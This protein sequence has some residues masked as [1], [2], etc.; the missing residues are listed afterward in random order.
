MSILSGTTAISGAYLG[1]DEVSAIFLGG[2]LVWSPFF[3]SLPGTLHFA[4]SGDDDTGDGSAGNPFRSL[5]MAN[6][7]ATPGRTIRLRGGDTFEGT[8][9]ATPGCTY[10]SY[11]TGQATVLSG[12]AVGCLMLNPDNT[13]V[14]DLIFEGAGTEVNATAGILA[15]NIHSGPTQVVGTIIR[16]CHVSEYGSNGIYAEV[17]NYPSGFTNL[18]IEDCVV[19]DCTGNDR[20]GHTAGIVVGAEN[21]WGLA[22]FPTSHI[23]PIVRGCEVYRCRGT[24]DASNHV[25]SGIIVAQFSGAIIE[26]CHAEECGENSTNIAGPVGIWFWDGRNGAIRRNTVVRQRSG[27]SDGG[28]YDLDGGCQNCVLEY[29]FSTGCT[30]PGILLFSFDDIGEGGVGTPVFLE[31]PGLPSVH[32]LPDFRDNTARFNVSIKDAQTSRSKYGIFI[33]SMRGARTRQFV[34]TDFQNIRV[35]NN[36]VVV[37][38]E[39]PICLGIGTF[40]RADISHATG[41]IT[42]NLFINLG[43]G[44]ICDIRRNNLQMYGNAYYSATDAS[45]RYFGFDWG[46]NVGSPYAHFISSTQDDGVIKEFRRNTQVFYVGDPVVSNLGGDDAADYRPLATSPL[47]GVAYDI[48]SEFGLPHPTQDFLGNA[49]PASRLR[50]FAPGA[51]EP[52][53]APTNRLTSPDDLT[54]GAWLKLGSTITGPFQ[55][56]D[57]GSTSGQNVRV[58]PTYGG[59]PNEQGYAMQQRTHATGPKL[60]RRGAFVRSE[61]VPV[62]ILNQWRTLFSSGG[63]DYPD[64]TDS[65]HYW[66]DIVEGRFVGLQ[67][68]GDYNIGLNGHNPSEFTQTN[69]RFRIQRRPNSYWLITQDVE[70]PD[71]YTSDYWSMLASNVFP[72]F[73]I[74]GNNQRGIVVDRSFEYLLG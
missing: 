21:F 58:D 36:T 33:G 39:N 63:F 37:G 40:E 28:A 1:E 54:N 72:A 12:M 59:D 66:W 18:L 6:A 50:L 24:V 56:V 74:P 16:R 70:I 13:I 3:E 8:I 2:R 65:L 51:M 62:A 55:G 38:P 73:G 34:T 29:N 53:G 43:S 57:P 49:I 25:G 27:R 48:A 42:G 15:L 10:E 31:I 26:E 11:G 9:L 20:T 61:N 68:N 69:T 45:M 64:N 41:I 44:L 17:E 14:Q 35:Y 47:I 5:D 67:V 32:R 71:S 52:V 60:L 7:L 30:G 46:P 4:E 19:E 22:T 23:N